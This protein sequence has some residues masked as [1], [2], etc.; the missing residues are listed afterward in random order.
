MLSPLSRALPFISIVDGLLFLVKRSHTACNSWLAVAVA[1]TISAL[2]TT[3]G[4]RSRWRR[5]NTS[6]GLL[7]GG[8]SRRAVKSKGKR[9]EEA[10]SQAISSGGKDKAK[11]RRTAKAKGKVKAKAMG[12]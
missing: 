6:E 2:R 5:Q 7:G 9:A 8:L 10:K 12:K 11:S 4:P 3:S 1:L